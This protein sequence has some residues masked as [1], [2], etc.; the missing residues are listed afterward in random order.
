MD[1]QSAGLPRKRQLRDNVTE[2]VA[3]ATALLVLSV[4]PTLK[5]Q[6]DRRAGSPALRKA[7]TLF[8]V[9]FSALMV[10]G[11]LVSGVHWATDIVGPVLLAGALFMLYH[12]AVNASDA[13]RASR[14]EG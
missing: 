9:A 13:G 7:T 3:N 10:A 4:M 5:F 1:A 11:R 6:I 8:V 2:R 12:C 14:M